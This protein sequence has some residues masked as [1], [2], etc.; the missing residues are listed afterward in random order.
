[1]EGVAD[2]EM[3]KALEL[4]N[5]GVVDW[6]IVGL[7]LLISVFIGFWVKRYVSDMATYIGAG[8]KVGTWLGVATMT[9][10]ELGL[11]TV[12]YMAQKGFSGGFA[13]FHLALIAGVA[14]LFIGLTGFIVAPL[15]RAR[16]L[17]IPEFYEKRFSR[18]VRVLG[19]VLLA[20]AGILNMGLFLQVGSKFLVG[21]TGL[22]IDGEVLKW[23]MVTLL[24][25]VL[26]YTTLGGM[27]SVVLTDYIQF[28][29]LSFGLIAATCLA[30]SQ[31]G[32]ANI[33]DTVSREMGEKGFDPVAEG[34]EFGPYYVA[35]MIIAAGLIGSAVWPTAVARA[36]AAESEKTLRRQYVWS[37]VSFT[38]RFMLPMFWGICAF[39]FIKTAAGGE[40]LRTL[41]F[42]AGEGIEPVD[43]LYALPMFM[44][45][46][47]PTMLL[48]VIAAAM[49]AAFMS[50]HDSYLLCWSSVIT[51]DIVAPLM[52][53]EVSAKARVNIT[54]VVI[55]LIG[56]FLLYWG[57][58]YKGKQDLWDYMAVSGGIYF[59]GA[60]VVLV[61]GI[62]WK[63]AS[64]VGA[65]LGLLSGFLMI[66]GLDPVQRAVGLK[67][68]DSSTGEMVERL[69]SAQ[70]GLIVVALAA[71]LMIAGSLIFPDRRGDGGED[72][73]QS[74]EGAG[75]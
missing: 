32:W 45:R 16:V 43:D 19:G 57:L 29:V 67:Y 20:F 15:R 21:I 26:V 56:V 5:F 38:I 14:T 72:Q 65:I 31:L 44:G 47:L 40:D 73:I 22:P 75:A 7:Y 50:T 17:T 24:V 1:M 34:S 10:T 37:S 48:G 27:I 52:G 23:V 70:V 68:E 36:L 28:V 51:Q 4:T 74:A 6:V 55:L 63:G 61:L 53:G 30:V 58:F 13:A 2:N 25:L 59:T 62:Y 12:M 46:L 33:F 39:V 71:L 60:F 3:A 54:R 9:G 18:S 64:S 49:I 41:F 11:V 42:P 66:F 35:W 69:S 8:R